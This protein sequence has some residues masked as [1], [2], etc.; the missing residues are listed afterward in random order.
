MKIFKA[1]MTV[2]L[3]AV[4]IPVS[5][6]NG[7]KLTPI[8][9]L[10]Q[11]V[12]LQFPKIATDATREQVHA[13]IEEHQP[14]LVY[15][16]AHHRPCTEW[17]IARICKAAAEKNT[18]VIIRIDHADQAGMI[19]SMLDLGLAGVKVPTV[20]SEEVVEA[21]IDG[22][23]FPPIGKRSLGGSANWAQKTDMIPEGMSYAEWWNANGILG[24]KL[25][26]VK[27]VLLSRYLAVP[28]IDF[29]DIGGSDLGYDIT[30]EK[31]PLF[32]NIQDCREFIKKSLE[33]TGVYF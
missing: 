22:F 4:L 15:L 1:L 14:D 25:E 20:E 7:Q 9:K 32:E 26:T 31:H 33:G 29:M 11:G 5:T 6:L 28:G 16:D 2:V 3:C 17:D 13:F 12:G 23:Y 10:Q 8:Q 21:I 18:G 30:I 19:S 27:G 24:I